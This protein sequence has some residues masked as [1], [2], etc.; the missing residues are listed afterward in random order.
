M[1]NSRSPS[2]G[3]NGPPISPP[4]TRSASADIS[5]AALVEDWRVYTQ[6]LRTQFDGEKAHMIADR[7]R[8]DEVMAEER[9][10]YE[11]ERAMLTARI[12]HLEAAA[13]AST[14]TG[15]VTV[16]ARDPSNPPVTS[17]PIKAP[18]AGS[19]ESSSRGIPQE[20]GRNADGTPFYAPAPRNPSR[21]FSSSSEERVDSIVTPDE[22]DLIRVTSKELKSSDFGL[23]T[24]QELNTIPEGPPESIDISHIQPELEG[25]S[26]KASA[27][28]AT[29]AA[30][31]LSPGRS[32]AKL[33]PNI[34]PPKQVEQEH[35]T[36]SPPRKTISPEDK[37]KMTLQV[38][39]QPENKRL[40]MHAGHT[41]SHSITKFE[42]LAGVHEAS[43]AATP[44]Q[45][46]HTDNAHRPSVAQG[47]FGDDGAGDAEEDDGEEDDGKEDD[48]DR[49]LSGL[50]TLSHGPAADSYF[51]AQLDSK[52]EEA[53]QKSGQ[54]SPSESGASLTSTTRPREVSHEEEVD[55]DEGPRLRLKPSF[56]FGKPMGR[57]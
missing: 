1:E 34:H 29:F 27:V 57:L 44:T 28:N 25:V 52:L 16:Q 2:Q 40:T 54:V 56:N 46:H 6:K 17:P 49:E 24:G 23:P 21:T 13:A 3:P 35:A 48:G 33:S 36:E 20:S 45:A 51:L 37:A 12:K 22:T 8:A 53:V 18:S 32:P 43:E 9:Q 10:L 14:S 55:K 31:I 15:N 42:D 19:G 41:P 5:V 38:V 39:G 4:K 30:K 26:I 50:L 47:N 7:A 11:Q